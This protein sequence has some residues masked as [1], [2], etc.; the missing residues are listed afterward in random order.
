M[1]GGD[2]NSPLY[3]ADLTYLLMTHHSFLDGESSSLYSKRNTCPFDPLARFHLWIFDYMFYRSSIR[4]STS[5]STCMSCQGPSDHNPI[6]MTIT[7]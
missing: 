6:Q 5:S 3:K 1:I 2:L 7:I 4:I